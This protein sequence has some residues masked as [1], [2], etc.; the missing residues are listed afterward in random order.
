MSN[1]LFSFRFAVLAGLAIA[2]RELWKRRDVRQF[3]A[4]WAVAQK[5]PTLY[6]VTLN[7]PEPIVKIEGDGARIIGV[8]VDNSGTAFHVSP[9]MVPDGRGGSRLARGTNDHGSVQL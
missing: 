1:P 8:T 3:E 7:R 2:G 9:R 4:L 5:K 6:R